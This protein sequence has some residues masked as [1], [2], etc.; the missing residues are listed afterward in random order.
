MKTK[1]Q[2]GAVG[3]RRLCEGCDQALAAA[4]RCP[5]GSTWSTKVPVAKP[6]ETTG[7]RYTP[8]GERQRRAFVTEVMKRGTRINLADPGD[9]V[10]AY[11]RDKMAMPHAFD[12]IDT[13]QQQNWIAGHMHAFATAEVARVRKAI[14]APLDRIEAHL[15]SSC[16]PAIE[17]DFA[18]IQ[19]ATK[20][21]AGRAKP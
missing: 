12:G 15:P 11:M 14:K 10:I 6:A 17:A 19:Q 8:T 1:R 9:R 2:P 7:K 18:A 16:Y 4:H 20:P 13:D 21:T 5:A 3:R